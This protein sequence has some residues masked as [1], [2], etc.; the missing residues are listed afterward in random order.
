[1]SQWILVCYDFLDECFHIYLLILFH[2]QIQQ[3]NNNNNNELFL[4]KQFE[5]QEVAHRRGFLSIQTEELHY[6]GINNNIR[7]V[8]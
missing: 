8:N 2:F 4:N 1:M 6:S 7:I 5:Y 3:H